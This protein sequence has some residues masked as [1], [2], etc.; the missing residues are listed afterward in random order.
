MMKDYPDKQSTG[1]ELVEKPKRG[2]RKKVIT[3]ENKQLNAT[4]GESSEPG[5]SSGSPRPLASPYPPE[6]EDAA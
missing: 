3:P 2:R 6:P 4:S 1:P 5:G